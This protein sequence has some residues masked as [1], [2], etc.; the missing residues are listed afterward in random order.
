MTTQQTGTMFRTLGASCP[1]CRAVHG[2]P[3]PDRAGNIARV[4]MGH[5]MYHTSTGREAACLLA[6]VPRNP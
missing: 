3:L 6:V 4:E 1:E 5:Q 2:L